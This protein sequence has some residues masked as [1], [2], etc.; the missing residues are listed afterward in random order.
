MVFYFIRQTMKSKIKIN[1]EII[2]LK[3]IYLELTQAA[4]VNS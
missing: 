3:K 1:M 2:Q 4:F